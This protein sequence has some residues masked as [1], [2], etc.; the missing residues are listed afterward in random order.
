MFF[1]F[2]ENKQ[3]KGQMMDYECILENIVKSGSRRR[4]MLRAYT[5]LLSPQGPGVTVRIL[6]QHVK[7]QG[8]HGVQG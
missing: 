5:H 7:I 2:N 8:G 6:N 4:R 1:I 3:S